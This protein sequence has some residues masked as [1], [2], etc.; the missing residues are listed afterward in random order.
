M[1][2]KAAVTN[3]GFCWRG[4]FVK[5]YAVI[6]D[7]SATRGNRSIDSPDHGTSRA[8]RVTPAVAFDSNGYLSGEA[9]AFNELVAASFGLG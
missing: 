5:P 9:T 7:P 1:G 6:A 2:S 3:P 8:V 4:G